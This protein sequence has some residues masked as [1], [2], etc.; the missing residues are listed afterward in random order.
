MAKKAK[1]ICL[2]CGRGITEPVRYCPYCAAPLPG[3]GLEPEEE[4]EKQEQDP[5]IGYWNFYG[6]APEPEEE[7]TAGPMGAR[8]WLRFAAVVVL[9]G[10]LVAGLAGNGWSWTFNWTSARLIWLI[11]L[12]TAV[13]LF[14]LSF[15]FKKKD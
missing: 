9:I 4:E 11:G 6:A 10:S 12:G 7:L 2:K 1:I 13:L 14:A 3:A 15:A 8:G 5:N